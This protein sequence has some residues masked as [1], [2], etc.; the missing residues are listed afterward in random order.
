VV[1]LFLPLL[2]LA[3]IGAAAGAA[4][5]VAEARSVV[6]LDRVVS[7]AGLPADLDGLRI[8]H[9]S[10]LHL[11]APGVN[12]AAARRAVALVQD[13]APDLIAITGDLLTHPRGTADLLNLLDGL[14]APLGVYA[15]LGNH[16]VGAVRD[17]FSRAG[18]V[19]DLASVGVELLRNRTLTIAKGAASIAITGFDPH[20]PEDE[21]NSLPPGVAWPEQTADLQLVLAHYPDVFD[22]APAAATGLVLSGH[23]HGGQI[24]VPWPS[25]RLRLSQLGHRYREGLYHRDGL[26]MHVSRGVGTT[27]V[28]FRFFARPEVTVLRVVG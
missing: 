23:L 20:R 25:G 10:D 21:T 15:T 2:G 13:A 4:A 7:L 3:A 24:C 27:F 18:D 11:G 1:V 19:P 14:E 6:R 26:T 12:R 22:A 28:P 5:G 17:P 8:A 9:V 16:D